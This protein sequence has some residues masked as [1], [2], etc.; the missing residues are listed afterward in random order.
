MS[1]RFRVFSADGDD[2]DD[3]ASNRPDWSPA[4]CSA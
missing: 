2:L 4:T 1:F 3:Y